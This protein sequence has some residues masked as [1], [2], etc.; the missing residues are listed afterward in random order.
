[1][2]SSE[3]S[4]ARGKSLAAFKAAWLLL[5]LLLLFPAARAQGQD[6]PAV[7]ESQDAEAQPQRPRRDGANLLMRLNLT[8]EQ[9]AQLR[10]IRRGSVPQERAFQRRLNAAR[11][12]LD[13][14]IY[15]DEASEA[16]VEDRARELSQAQAALARLRAQTE[17]RVRRVLTAEQLQSFRDLRQ[18]A[19][20]RQRAQRRRALRNRQQ[21]QPLQSAPAQSPSLRPQA[22]P[23]ATPGQPRPQRPARRRP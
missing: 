1:M 6:T 8:P 12:A 22:Q 18:R 9:R 15:S 13:E 17:L 11:R 19:R 20:L 3:T 7:A 10:E 23:A 5:P 16:L 4:H 21:Q 2:L 14:A